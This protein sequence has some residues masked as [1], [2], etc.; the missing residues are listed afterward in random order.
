MEEQRQRTLAEERQQLAIARQLTAQI[1]AVERE[2]SNLTLRTLLAIEAARHAQTADAIEVLA[3]SLAVLPRVRFHAAG[4]V[5]GIA[6][7]PDSR[8]LRSRKPESSVR[9]GPR[10]GPRCLH[11][12]ARVRRAR[13]VWPR[14]SSVHR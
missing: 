5:T 14:P 12:E 8:Y 4:P 11:V 13:P 10:Q 6:M 3:G 2:T 1:D 9:G 7:S